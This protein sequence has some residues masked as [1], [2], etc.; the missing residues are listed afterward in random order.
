MNQTQEKKPAS[1][2][3]CCGE[4]TAEMRNV[5]G[6]LG[7]CARQEGNELQYCRL[8]KQSDALRRWDD[9]PRHAEEHRLA[10]LAFLHLS[11]IDALIP[12]RPRRELKAL[13]LRQQHASQ[14]RSRAHSE[15]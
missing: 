4:L 10:P 12:E 6:L 14:M 7:T 3:P 15:P 11:A 1:K 8:I 13:V 2:K 5:L 9:L